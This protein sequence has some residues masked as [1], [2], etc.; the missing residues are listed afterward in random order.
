MTSSV[1]FLIVST[2]EEIN[3]TEL[4]GR[5]NKTSMLIKNKATKNSQSAKPMLLT[6]PRLEAP[7]VST[8]LRG[9]V[10]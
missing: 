2:N 7:K 5:I 9:Q 6:Y 1:A 4:T 8:N 3:R 10:R